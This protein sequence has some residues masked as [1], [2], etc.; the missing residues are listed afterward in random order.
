MSI[1]TDTVEMDNKIEFTR[2]ASLVLIGQ[3]FLEKGIWSIIEERVHVKQKVRQHT[4]HEKL[5]DA[6]IA[7]LSGSHGLVEVN[8]RVRPDRAVQLAFGRKSCAEQSTISDTMDACTSENVQQLR[9][10][11]KIILRIQGQCYQHDYTQQSQLLD[12]DMTGLT[13]GR[14]GEGVTK[15]YFAHQRQRRGRQLGRV[16]ATH[17]DEL[18]VERLYVGKRQLD[19]SFQ[20]LILATEDVLNLLEN[21]RQNTILRMDGGGGD[22]ANINW[23]LDRKYHLLTKVRNWQRAYKLA[24]TVTQWYRDPKI[25]DREVGWVEQPKQ[26]NRPTRQLALRHPKKKKDGSMGWHYHVL[27]FTLTDEMLFKLCQRPMPTSPAAL[28]LMLAAAYAYDKRD[29]GLETQNR[30]DKQGLGLSHRNKRSFVAQEMLILLAQLAHNV[31]IWSRNQMSQVESRF[32]KFG[33]QRTTRD[34]FQIDGHVLLSPAGAIESV[35][36]NGRHPHASAFQRAFG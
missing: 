1:S 4:P 3:H 13:A 29:G 19:Q 35:V 26:Y 10:A 36:L 8:T 24:Q 20:E 30:G 15:G 28:E 33:I 34:L 18:V 21:K 31:V 11:L 25:S 14:Q 9:E 23:A 22:D 12:I 32:N 5:L 2:Q 17:Y 7:I 27:V 6:F 16:L